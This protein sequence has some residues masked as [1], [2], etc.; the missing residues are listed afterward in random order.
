MATLARVL[1]TSSALEPQEVEAA[2][3]AARGLASSGG[4]LFSV[5]VENVNVPDIKLPRQAVDLLIKV[6]AEMAN[7]NT[8]S[9]VPHE[10]ELTTQQAAD[11]L[12]VSRPHVIKLLQSGAIPF[13]MVGTHRKVKARDVVNYR[14]KDALHRSAMLDRMA[15]LD[16][17][18]GLLGEDLESS[19]V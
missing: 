17:E 11:F 13:R 19:N 15:E 9:I 2:Q 3:V 18:I 10:S 16:Q 7:G 8:V 5:K 6:L 4:Q 14:D 12:N 1:D